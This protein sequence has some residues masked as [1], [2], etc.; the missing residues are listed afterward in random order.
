MPFHTTTRFF[1]SLLLGALCCVSMGVLLNIASLEA[2]PLKQPKQNFGIILHPKDDT[3]PSST[4]HGLKE[5]SRQKQTS[6]DMTSEA[7]LLAHPDKLAVK[8]DVPQGSI[9]F[10]LFP[11]DS[12]VTV[13]HWLKLYKN[14]CYPKVNAQ[15]A[16]TGNAMI[17]HRVVENFV[18]QTGDPT[19]TGQGA[20]P[21]PP[22]TLEVHNKL[23]HEAGTVAMARSSHPNS[24][25][26]QFYITMTKQPDLDGKYAIF[27]RV[28]QG[29]ALV[30]L[31][32][33]GTPLQSISLVPLASVTPD[34]KP[35]KE[36]A[37]KHSTRLKQAVD[38]SVMEVS[39]QLQ[40]SFF[41]PKLPHLGL[42]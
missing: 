5:F 23:I 29:L 33:Q 36:K 12:P 17:F 21:A 30:P 27:G 11:E 6:E 31:V 34:P 4:R 40:P 38:H 39:D 14:Q 7:W 41:A 37:L 28:I 22:L 20:C 15:G 19:G 25:R 9:Y 13:S 10:R 42:K 35:K 2:S 24:A 8:V 3:H 32:A 1:L 16:F 26:S 18:I